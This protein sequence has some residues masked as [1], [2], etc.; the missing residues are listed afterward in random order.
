MASRRLASVF[1]RQVSVLQ[2]R[3]FQTCGAQLGRMSAEG[4][5]VAIKSISL[6]PEHW[7]AAFL[8]REKMIEEGVTT[9]TGTY[10]GL[11]AV[12]LTSGQYVKAFQV[13]D[14]FA[15]SGLPPSEA[16]FD[17]ALELCHRTGDWQRACDV[18]AHMRRFSNASAGP[19]PQPTPNHQPTKPGLSRS[20]SAERMAAFRRRLMDFA[21]CA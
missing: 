7:K 3:H 15:M 17:L 14:E 21:A 12:C 1:T 6:V 8:L 9:T 4:F 18:I 20:D 11:V 13:W 2:P 5:N 19:L 10:D 16:T